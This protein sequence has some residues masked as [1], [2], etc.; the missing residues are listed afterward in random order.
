MIYKSGDAKKIDISEKD[1]K[2]L[3]ELLKNA[4]ASYSQIEKNTGILRD[5]IA[6]RVLKM[7]KESLIMGYEMWLD[8]L[9]M[10]YNFLAHLFIKMEAVNEN[11]S[12]EFI[13]KLVK[14][15]NIT[16]VT[17]ILGNY[18]LVLV[19]VARDALHFDQIVNEIKN[20]KEKVVQTVDVSIITGDPKINDFSG[21]LDQ[22]K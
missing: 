5:T 20:N 6:K 18:D 4:R 21:L 10:G 15:P 13:E 22:I 2:I 19:V 11:L 9:A 7:K 17:T 16:H 1:K 3:H 14:M 8:P 12:K